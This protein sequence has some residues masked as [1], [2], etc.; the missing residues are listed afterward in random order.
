M[1]ERAVQ[2]ANAVCSKLSFEKATPQEKAYIIRYAHIAIVEQEKYGIPAS[3]TLAQGI[4]ESLAGT[5]YLAKTANNHFGIK[6]PGKY[7]HKGHNCINRSD[8]HHWDRFQ[9]YGSP[10]LSFRAHSLFL[11]QYPRYDKLFT[12]GIDYKKWA[13]GLSKAGYATNKSY[14]QTLIKKIK[15]L[16]LDKFD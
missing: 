10:W 8:D 9:N 3:I 5:S 11:K 12:Y 6:C 4:I 1:V 2:K 15:S 13:Y 7:G 16:G 14:P